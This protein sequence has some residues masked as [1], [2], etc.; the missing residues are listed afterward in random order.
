MISQ[1]EPPINIG[2]LPLKAVTLHVY[3]GKILIIGPNGMRKII[4]SFNP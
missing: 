4:L 2:N 3:N 1:L